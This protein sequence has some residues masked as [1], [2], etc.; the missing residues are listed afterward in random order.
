MSWNKWE[1]RAEAGPMTLVVWVIGCV[2]VLS[3][4]LGVIRFAMM[5]FVQAA[6]VAEKT[7]DADNT[8]ATRRER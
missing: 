2:L 6:R 5:P 4:G 7:L 1:K 8:P 3:V